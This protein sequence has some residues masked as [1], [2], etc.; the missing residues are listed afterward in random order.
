MC[1]GVKNKYGRQMDLPSDSD[2][3]NILCTKYKIDI[4]KELMEIINLKIEEQT[5]CTH[6]FTKT[7]YYPTYSFCR[8]C[9]LKSDC[10]S[11][12]SIAVS[13]EKYGYNSTYRE[14]IKTKCYECHKM[15]EYTVCTTCKSPKC[16][17]NCR[18]GCS[19]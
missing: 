11:C 17:C 12:L 10:H 14:Y 8:K 3:L 16:W 7:S 9:E 15:V 19:C 4:E 18:C 5:N 1:K 6:D 2:L 13:Y